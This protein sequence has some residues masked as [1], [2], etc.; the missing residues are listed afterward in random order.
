MLAMMMRILPIMTLTQTFEPVIA[1]TV[2]SGINDV[3]DDI[4]NESRSVMTA[5]AEIHLYEHYDGQENL[6]HVYGSSKSQNKKVEL[7]IKSR[8]QPT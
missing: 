2:R 4:Q 5:T 7:M 3:R 6:R 1:T 8:E